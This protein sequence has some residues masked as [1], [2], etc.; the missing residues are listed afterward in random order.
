MMAMREVS[1]TAGNQACQS[2]SIRLFSVQ[3]RLQSCT[4]GTVVCS[5]TGRMYRIVLN[6][7]MSTSC[8]EK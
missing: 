4:R 7:Y 5:A 2:L 3:I 1:F 6:V 8:I